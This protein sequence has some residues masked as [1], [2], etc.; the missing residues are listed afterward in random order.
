MVRRCT[1]HNSMVFY[2][3][4]MINWYFYLKLVI[5]LYMGLGWDAVTKKV[6]ADL[7]GDLLTRKEGRV[8]LWVGW[9]MVIGVVTN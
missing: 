7:G 2:Q 8:G 4:F 9:Y 6:R 5:T 1:I 3:S